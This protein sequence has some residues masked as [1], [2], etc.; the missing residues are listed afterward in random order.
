PPRL[1]TARL[2]ALRAIR[3]RD[4][5]QGW[6]GRELAAR[7][8]VVRDKRIDHRPDGTYPRVVRRQLGRDGRSR[9]TAALAH[10]VG[11][12]R[13]I[14]LAAGVAGAVGVLAPA[15]VPGTVVATDGAGAQAFTATINN[16]TA[17]QRKCLTVLV[18]AHL[19]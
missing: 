5:Q 11:R 1:H 2:V 10:V 9:R 17:I 15:G 7:A 13:R 3:L 12:S 14:G 4:K 18:I 19:P 6:H 8:G 16:N